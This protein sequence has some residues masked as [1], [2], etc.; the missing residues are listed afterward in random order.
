MTS[1]SFYSPYYISVGVHNN[2]GIRSSFPLVKRVLY[3]AKISSLSLISIYA[4]YRFL[5]LVVHMFRRRIIFRL[6][7]EK[8]KL[9]RIRPDRDRVTATQETIPKH[10]DEDDASVV[11][12]STKGI[13][14]KDGRW[15]AYSE[16]GALRSNRIVLVFHSLGSCRLEKH[17]TIHES[18]AVQSNI[19]FVHVDRPGYGQSDACT[20]RRSLLSFASDVHELLNVLFE[21][22]S[23]MRS[24]VWNHQQQMDDGMLAMAM[25]MD[26]EYDV[27]CEFACLGMD[28]GAAFAMATAY[29]N[30]TLLSQKSEDASFVRRKIPR[31]VACTCISAQLPY[32]LLDI[33]HFSPHLRDL[34]LLTR[35]LLVPMLKVFMYFDLVQPVFKEPETYTKKIRKDENQMYKEERPEDLERYLSSCV[36]AL[37]EGM[38]LFGI[39]EPTR[40]IKMMFEEWGFNISDLKQIPVTFYHGELSQRIPISLVQQ[41]ASTLPHPSKLC[42]IPKAG[43]LFWMDEQIFSSIIDKLVTC[44]S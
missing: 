14:L 8:Q 38:N 21:G 20:D 19:R 3:L 36:Q 37:R 43:D 1:T 22:F 15:L 16:Y 29:Y 32:R 41:I 13:L 25:N 5:H 18:V 39:R 31:C 11:S 24:T 40:E 30:Q 9:K 12:S 2:K 28:V 33:H 26:E 27:R 35:R 4:I 42:S 17:P 23:T 34:S 10:N 7:R 44:F 6:A